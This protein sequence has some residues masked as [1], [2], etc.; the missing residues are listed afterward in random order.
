MNSNNNV[1]DSGISVGVTITNAAVMSATVSPSSTINSA[2]NAYS[3][4]ISA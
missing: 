4:T 1:I 2:I 3:F